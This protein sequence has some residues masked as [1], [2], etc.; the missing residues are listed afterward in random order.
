MA[1]EQKAFELFSEHVTKESAPATIQG[2]IAAGAEQKK[3]IREQ[4][5]ELPQVEKDTWVAKAANRSFSDLWGQTVK[6]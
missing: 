1:N 6:K 4:W 3:S 2:E 5:E